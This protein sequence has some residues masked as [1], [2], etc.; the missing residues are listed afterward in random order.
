MSRQKQTDFDED[1]SC[2]GSKPFTDGSQRPIYPYQR[3]KVII[4]VDYARLTEVL[5][6]ECLL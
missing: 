3:V 2:I 5:C 1:T 4:I 6:P